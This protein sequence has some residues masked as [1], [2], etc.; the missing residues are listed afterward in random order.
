MSERPGQSGYAR[1][2]EITLE[3]LGRRTVTPTGIDPQCCF[4]GLPPGT[5]TVSVV[6]G[7]NPFGCWSPIT[8]ELH[9]RSQFVSFPNHPV[10]PTASV[11][12]IERDDDAGWRARDRPPAL[13]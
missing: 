13:T 5:Y 8:V 12:P 4:D 6:A 3:P 9:E 10:T 7:C 1:G 11:A 2:V